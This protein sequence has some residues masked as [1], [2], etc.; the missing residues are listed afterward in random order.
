MRKISEKYQLRDILQTISPIRLKPVKVITKQGKSE[1][2]TAKRSLRIHT[3]LLNVLWC[4]GWDP[5][6]EKSIREE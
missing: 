4:P 3:G 5:G 1:K 2:L 6:T